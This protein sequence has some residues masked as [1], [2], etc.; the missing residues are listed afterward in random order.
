MLHSRARTDSPCTEGDPGKQCVS[1]EAGSEHP[2]DPEHL[3]SVYKRPQHCPSTGLTLHLL[4]ASLPRSAGHPTRSLGCRRAYFPKGTVFAQ[5]LRAQLRCGRE[6]K[7]Q[8]KPDPRRHL[9]S[10]GKQALIRLALACMGLGKSCPLAWLWYPFRLNKRMGLA[11]LCLET[12]VAIG[13]KCAS[14]LFHTNVNVKARGVFAPEFIFL[15]HK[16]EKMEL[17][18][19]E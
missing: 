4:S 16:Q 6:R 9:R 15:Y 10:E 7:A 14:P 5:V 17:S 11:L 19:C 8:I 2:T 1:Q 3:G 12:A 18:H 13:E